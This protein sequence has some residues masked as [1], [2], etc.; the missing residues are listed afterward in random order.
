M[1]D[2]LQQLINLQKE[3]LELLKKH[4]WR[5]RFSQ[6]TL[7]LLTTGSCIALGY[8]SYQN[9]ASSFP[10]SSVVYSSPQPIP[11]G[12]A[13]SPGQPVPVT[14]PGYAIPYVASPEK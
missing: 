10:P 1:D 9:R 8:M 2:Q 5:L 6:L 14:I 13:G 11:A 12:T 4:L 3:Q 7:L